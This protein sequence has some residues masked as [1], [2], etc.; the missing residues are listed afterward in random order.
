MNAEMK[1]LTRILLVCL[2]VCIVTAPASL[3]RAQPLEEEAGTI[4]G[5]LS[6]APLDSK[7]EAVA[8]AR[9][10]SFISADMVLVNANLTQTVWEL[11]FVGPERDQ[12]GNYAKAVTVGLSAEDSS[13]KSLSMSQRPS[14]VSGGG[15]A[16]DAEASPISREQAE[17][18]ARLFID[19]LQLEIDA[20]WMINRYSESG[21]DTRFE[22]E[23]LYKV[24]FDRA[25]NGIRYALQQFIV[26]VDQRGTIISYDMRWSEMDF[27]DPVNIISLE[28]AQNRIFDQVKP[29]LQFLANA[30]EPTLVYSLSTYMVDPLTGEFPEDK[31]ENP[32]FPV[33][34][35]KPISELVPETGESTVAVPIINEDAAKI[36]A[37]QHIRAVKPDYFHKLAENFSYYTGPETGYSEPEYVFHFERIADGIPVAGDYIKATVEVNSGRVSL[38]AFDLSEKE[39][40]ETVAPPAISQE[41]AKRLLLSLYVVELQYLYTDNSRADLYYRLVLG[42]SVPV[43]YNGTAPFLD[44]NTGQWRS[45]IGYPFEEVFP[46]DNAWV[47]DIISSVDRIEYEAAIVL[48]GQVLPFRNEPVIQEGIT[49]A[50]FRELLEKMGAVVSWHPESQQVVAV[51]GETRLELQINSRTAYRNGQMYELEVPAQLINDSTF[52]PVRFAAEALGAA[53]NWE[54]ES[55]LVRIHDRGAQASSEA[56]LKQWRVEAQKQWEAGHWSHP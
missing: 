46:P 40:P 21:N 28:E 29:H 44:A 35:R 18:T 24:R 14:A 34:S 11:S 49:L 39:Y 56:E 20:A 2:A 5:Q 45:F 3:T 10:F 25:V 22:D 23:S 12:N 31:Y 30:E 13:L 1:E 55:R 36:A 41:R 16:S 8:R 6:Q 37:V 53:V 26:F 47:D 33:G 7:E 17:E 27:A 43:F 50:P 54:A 32:Y 51:K 9:L 19:G 38:S 15:E 52:I 48:D 42:P 4:S